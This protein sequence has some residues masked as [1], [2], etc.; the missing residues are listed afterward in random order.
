[1]SVYV[2]DFHFPFGN[3]RMS[4]LIADQQ[5]ELDAFAVRLGLHPK[6]KHNDHYDVSDSKRDKAIELGAI[7]VSVQEGAAIIHGQRMAKA[8][9]AERPEGSKHGQK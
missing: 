6:W 5:S 9:K 1:M 8:R 4:H 2:D 3:M 7:R